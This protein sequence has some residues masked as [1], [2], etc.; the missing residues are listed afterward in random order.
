[1]FKA[2]IPM[3]PGVEEIEAVTIIDILRRAQ[4]NVTVAATDGLTVKASRDVVIVCDCHWTDITPL[5]YDVLA[6]PG[7][8]KGVERLCDNHLILDAIRT[9]HSA[10]RL[11]GAICAAPLALSAAGILRDRRISCHPTVAGRIREARI[12]ESPVSHDGR[13]IT[14]RGAGTSIAFAL[15]LVRAEGGIREADDIS[16]AIA[17][18]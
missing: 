18:P 8:A 13:L 2:L 16:R 17:C 9:M 15:A 10:G 12:S 1:M 5:D 3:A 6:L 11:I 14:S 4:W 7:G